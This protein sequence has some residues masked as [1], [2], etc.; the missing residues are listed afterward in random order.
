MKTV[1]ITGGSGLIGR[2]LSKALRSK[3]YRVT[4]LSRSKKQS[5]D[6][7]AYGWDIESGMI[8]REAL[9]H[10]D[11]IV[12]LAGENIFQMR[13]TMARKQS[14]IDSRVKAAKFIFEKINELKV[15]PAAF[16]SASAVGYYGLVTTEK[17]FSE[18]DLPRV[19][20]VSETCQ[21]WEKAADQFSTIGIRTV[22]I[23]TSPVLAADGGILP[24]M[25][26]PVRLGLG[27]AF[28]SGIQYFPWIHIDDICA[29][30]IKAIEDAGMNGVYNASAPDYVTNEQIIREL[31]RTLKKPY[32]LPHIPAS[33]LKLFFGER[34]EM[35]LNGSRV[36]SEKILNAGFTFQFPEL[37]MALNNLFQK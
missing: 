29:V 25:A 22:K 11:Y 34:A 8:E 12:H 28:G 19:D 4:I 30:Y 6:A 15:K 13:W 31:A 26:K 32:W 24:M 9:I 37:T 35:I 7:I 3:G 36:S 21:L 14:I 27:A 33:F 1:L 17:I 2:H 23:R 5:P 18:T 16:I 10:A 20:F